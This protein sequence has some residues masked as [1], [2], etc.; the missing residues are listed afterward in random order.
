MWLFFLSNLAMGAS[1]ATAVVTVPPT[2]ADPEKGSIYLNALYTDA[3]P[4][5]GLL[6]P[7]Q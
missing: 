7:L 3:V 2:A 1:P 4:D 6:V 5:K